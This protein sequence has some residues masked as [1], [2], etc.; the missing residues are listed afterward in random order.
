MKKE[1]YVIIL[2]LISLLSFIGGVWIIIDQLGLMVALGILLIMGSSRAE[3]KM[4]ELE[5]EDKDAR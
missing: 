1:T 3:L 2:A 4:R 5:K